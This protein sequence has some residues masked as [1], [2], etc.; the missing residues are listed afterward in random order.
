MSN[1]EEPRRSGARIRRPEGRLIDY[2]RTVLSSDTTTRV[3]SRTS[4]VSRHVF[5]FA[6]KLVL[7]RDRGVLTKEE[8]ETVD[9]TF[10]ILEQGDYVL[11]VAE[12]RE[13]LSKYWKERTRNGVYRPRHGSQD[14]PRGTNRRQFRNDRKIFNVF[15]RTLFA[16][17][18][19][20]SRLDELKIPQELN[21]DG[22]KEAED[23]LIDSLCSITELLTRVRKDPSNE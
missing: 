16:I 8:E 14:S 9:R 11:A 5:L 1:I 19:T 3:M 7:V 17:R 4:D 13:V 21:R 6:R 12:A 23:V 18:E 2:I 15:D 20:C 10:Q 22:R